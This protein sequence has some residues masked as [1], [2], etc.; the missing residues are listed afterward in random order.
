[1]YAFARSQ[2]WNKN[3]RVSVYNTKRWQTCLCGK[4]STKLRCY[5]GR[6]CWSPCVRH[7]ST[8]TVCPNGAA[9]D[10]IVLVK[11]QVS[12]WS[13]TWCILSPAGIY[14]RVYHIYIY[15]YIYV[16]MY[17][18]SYIYIYTFTFRY[19]VTYWFSIG[20]MRVNVVLPL[21]SGVASRLEWDSATSN[22]YLYTKLVW[23]VRANVKEHIFHFKKYVCVSTGAHLS[24]VLCLSVLA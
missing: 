5:S 8:Q 23:V 18:H 3:P 24:V 17:M 6:L 7:A 10:L 11:Q 2:P 21:P 15:I 4:A 12:K 16:L 14:T 1:M 20:T 19:V 9:T 13:L 22:N